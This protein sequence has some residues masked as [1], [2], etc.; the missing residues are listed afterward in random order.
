[1]CQLYWVHKQGRKLNQPEACTQQCG[2]P[3]ISPSKVSMVVSLFP[4]FQTW[5]KVWS[6]R[7]GPEVSARAFVW[8]RLDFEW[9]EVVLE[10]TH[11]GI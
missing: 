2:N 7:P 4:H 8:S 5:G 1:M 11:A 6:F 3:V 9:D 10:E